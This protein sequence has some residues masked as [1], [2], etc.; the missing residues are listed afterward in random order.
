M[1]L[2]PVLGPAAYLDLARAI[3]FSPSRC[4]I[5]DGMR[6]GTGGGNPGALIGSL[7]R[8]GRDSLH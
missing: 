8:L 7:N 2:R 6:R 4:D 5:G 3:A 1:Q